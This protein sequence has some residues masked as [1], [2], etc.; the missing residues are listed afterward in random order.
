MWSIF[1]LK[2]GSYLALL[3]KKF[4]SHELNFCSKNFLNIKVGT[5]SKLNLSITAGTDKAAFLV[6]E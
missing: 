6:K 5:D 3:S 2:Q 4:M 1:C